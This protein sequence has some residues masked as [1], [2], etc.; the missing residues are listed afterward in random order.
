[1][2]L[3]FLGIVS[4]GVMMKSSTLHLYLMAACLDTLCLQY[5]LT[6]LYIWLFILTPRGWVVLPTHCIPHVHVIT[7]M[8]LLVPQLRCPLMLND[9][10]VVLLC[11]VQ[12]PLEMLEPHL[13]LS[14]LHLKLPLVGPLGNDSV[15]V[16]DVMSL[17]WLGARTF[18]RVLARLKIMH[19][20][21]DVSS[22]KWGSFFSICQCFVMICLISLWSWLYLVIKAHL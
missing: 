7:Y 20:F 18:F 8:T 6:I 17:R 12:T 11:I 5:P 14:C 9:F 13:H 21:S 19:G 16:L 10:F 15:F 3:V 22:F 1:M 4:T 2:F